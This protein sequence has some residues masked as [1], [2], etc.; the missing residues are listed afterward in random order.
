MYIHMYAYNVCIYYIMHT[1][2]HTH[3][4]IIYTNTHVYVLYHIYVCM[5]IYIYIS[6]ISA[7]LLMNISMP[8]VI[9]RASRAFVD[10]LRDAVNEK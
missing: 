1:H 9:G 6:V 8:W 3:T 5:Y 10:L 7:Y 4:Q 2:T